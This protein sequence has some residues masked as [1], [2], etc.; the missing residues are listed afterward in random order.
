MLKAEYHAYTAYRIPQ[1]ENAEE[2]GVSGSNAQYGTKPTITTDTSM[3]NMQHI[4]SAIPIPM[5][6]SR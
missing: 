4:D 2:I 6:R 1:L 5:G 3:Y